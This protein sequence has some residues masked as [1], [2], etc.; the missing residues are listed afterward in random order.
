MARIIRFKSHII[1]VIIIA[2]AIVGFLL[3]SRPAEAQVGIQTPADGVATWFYQSCSDIEP[4]DI[5][6]TIITLDATEPSGQL[7]H[8]NTTDGYP[9]YRFH[10]TVS[11][12]NTG[13]RPIQLTA[14]AVNNPHPQKLMVSAQPDAFQIGKTLQPCGSI[15]VWGTAPA[16]LPDSCTATIVLDVLVLPDAK[17]QIQYGYAI[18]VA[19]E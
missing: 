10:C 9:G 3:W 19:L 13:N 14:V 4:A 17:Q 6:E 18:T 7:L 12:A 15:P 8:I 2:V 5:A 16:T 1:A 11:L